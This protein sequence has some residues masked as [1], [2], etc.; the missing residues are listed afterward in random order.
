MCG[1]AGIIDF[2]SGAPDERLLRRMLGLIR[3]RGPDAC[4]MYRDNVAGLAHTRLSIID[5]SSGDQP[6]HNED[7]TL[8]IIFNGEVFNYPELRRALKAQGHQFYTRSDTEVLVHLYE[9]HGPQFVNLLNGQFALGL[10]DS[11]KKELFLARDRLGIRPLFY[12]VN[13]GRLAFA[14]EIKAL[15]AD[16]NMDRTL[17]IEALSDVFTCWAPLGPLTPFKEVRQLLPGQYASFSTA[18]MQIESYW[19][20]PFSVSGHSHRSLGEWTEELTGLLYDATRIRLRADVPVGAYL[21][22]GLDSTYIS[23]LVRR[24]FNNRLCTFSV[25]FTDSRFD[26]TPFQQRAVKAL[27][28]DHRSVQCSEKD[29]GEIFPHVIWHTETPILRT[30]PAPLF[31][32]SGLVR[33]NHFKVVLTGEGA[34][35]VFAGYNIFKEDKVRRFWARQPDSKLR[36]RLLER[37]YPY[38]FSQGNGRARAFLE[39]FFRKSLTQLESPAYSHMIRWAN[40]SS[41][42]AFFSD[43]LQG[44]VATL[45]DFAERHISTLPADFMSWDPLAR[46]QYTEM[47]IF[48]SN[49][50]LSSQGDRM[51]MGHSVEGRFPFLDHRVVEFACRIPVHYRLNGLDEKFILKQVAGDLVPPE[52]I[53]RPKQPYRAPISRCFFG[54]GTP[55]Y[56]G[57]LLSENAIKQTGYFHPKKVA[58]LLKKCHKQDGHLASERENMALVGI[59]S[60]QLVDHLFIRHFPPYPVDEPENVQVTGPA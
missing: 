23:S 38:V 37:L 58:H 12:S 56:V 45:P 25:G 1:I 42:K 55:D 44:H 48:L 60:T 26:E 29:I 31:K 21:S 16:S 6:I 54:K 2:A 13:N 18:G 7:Q 36:P 34:D 3:H 28:T 10:W 8:W 20:P 30:A 35:E 22:G 19:Q 47:T 27:G 11:R 46:A 33:E 39:G 15:M 9:D 59:L 50:L 4:G 32:L 53:S 24:S 40:T 5:L 14:S 41:L 51:A 43:E 17:D 49:Y 57:E 52:L